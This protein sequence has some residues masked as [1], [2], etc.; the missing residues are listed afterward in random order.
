MQG[1]HGDVLSQ[2]IVAQIFV[3]ITAEFIHLFR[4]PHEGE[5]HPQARQAVK[6]RERPTE[7]HIRISAYESCD[8][9]YV[10]RHKRSVSLIYQNN[11]I[12]RR[13]LPQSIQFV[14]RQ[15]VS[16]RIIGRSHEHHFR[17]ML[18]NAAA[19]RLEVVSE[20]IFLFVDGILQRAPVDLVRDRLI[21][22]PRILRNEHRVT[23]RRFGQKEVHSLLQNVFGPITQDDLRFVHTI[24]F[25]ERNRENAFLPFI[26]KSRV[27]AQFVDVEVFKSFD[28]FRRRLE[29]KLIS[30]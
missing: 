4:A 24:I 28:Y 29:V 14:G 11:R 3:R 10:V 30:I 5:A 12:S 21:I 2:P 6:F 20:T 9:A 26:V 16:G 1:C 23:P 19:Q 13:K 17:L 7:N 25:S 22:P 27:E 18:L 15:S 8:I